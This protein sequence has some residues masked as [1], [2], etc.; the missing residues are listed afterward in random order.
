MD[1]GYCLIMNNYDEDT[2]IL[3]F[4]DPENAR[5]HIRKMLI[6]DINNNHQYFKHDIDYYSDIDLDELF[7]I[8]DNYSDLY[9]FFK[10]SPNDF[11]IVEIRF[12]DFDDPPGFLK[13]LI[14]S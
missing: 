3:F 12:E 14:G 7:E 10:V 6:E 5:K 11:S 1:N 8:V 2:T 13:R 9:L 4:R